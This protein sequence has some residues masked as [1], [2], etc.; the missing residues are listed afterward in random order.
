MNLCE[1]CGEETGNLILEDSVSCYTCGRQ[2]CV[3]C[4][5]KWY[6][7]F[8]CPYDHRSCGECSCKDWKKYCRKMEK[9]GR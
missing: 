6:R 1:I 4:G 5:E 3:T 8:D 7:C 9:C 2:T